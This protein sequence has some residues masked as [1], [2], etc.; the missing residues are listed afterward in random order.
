MDVFSEARREDGLIHRTERKCYK[1]LQSKSGGQGEVQEGTSGR[2]CS[3]VE[4][5]GEELNINGWG[6][7]P[8]PSLF[9]AV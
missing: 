6:G 4:A 5:Q 8:P 3:G 2:M 1:T 9:T 7:Q